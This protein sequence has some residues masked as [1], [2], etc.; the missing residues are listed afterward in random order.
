MTD[1]PGDHAELLAILEEARHLG[2]LGPGPVEDHVRHGYG[3]V[4]AAGSYQRGL[5]IDLGSGAGVPGLMLALAWPEGTIVLVDASERRTQFLTSAVRRLDLGPP[6]VSVVR[7][8]AEAVGRQVQW[9]QS[10]DLVVARG[11]GRPALIA[12]CA[13]PLLREGGRL[14]VSEPP[15]EREGRWPEAG[16]EQLG[17]RRTARVRHHGCW[18]QTL[19]QTEPSPQRFPRR[20]GIPGKRPLF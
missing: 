19:G 14:I 6:R 11:F 8:R 10:A 20:P 4:A 2:Y 9:R 5:V 1:L 3:F 12:E 16:L 17:L 18:Y 7:G 15:E 13:A